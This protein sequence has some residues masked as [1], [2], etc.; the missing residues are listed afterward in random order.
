[1]KQIIIIIYISLLLISCGSSTTVVK[2]TLATGA[3]CDNNYSCS[4]GD[5]CSNSTT[6]VSVCKSIKSIIEARK[7]EKPSV[8]KPIILNPKIEIEYDEFK[9]QTVSTYSPP[10]KIES[11]TELRVGWQVNTNGKE[12]INKQSTI[13]AIIH[14]ESTVWIFLKYYKDLTLLIDGKRYIP[15]N[16]KHDGLATSHS[17]VHEFIS[18]ELDYDMADRIASAASVRGKLSWKEFSLTES[19]KKALKVMITK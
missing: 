13:T 12:K 19:D 7:K 10:F 9:D 1:M 15:Q 8:P 2:P 3:R 14:S 6:K 18:F 11:Y 17:S 5:V 4:D 16:I